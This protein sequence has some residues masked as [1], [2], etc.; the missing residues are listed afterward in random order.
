MGSN[1]CEYLSLDSVQAPEPEDLAAAEFHLCVIDLIQPLS[2]LG[3]LLLCGSMP[4]FLQELQGLGGYHGDELNRCSG[5]GVSE[6]RQRPVG[7]FSRYC[8][9]PTGN[10]G[11]SIRLLR[12][13]PYRGKVHHICGLA[14]DSFCACANQPFASE[15]LICPISAFPLSL[16][17]VLFC[18]NG[19]GRV[20]WATPKGAYGSFL[21]V[22]GEH[23]VPEL[24]HV[25]HVLCLSELSLGPCQE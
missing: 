6:G 8:F 5:S 2:I 1:H 16:P 19:E 15:L 20:C 24:H 22:L 23:E 4:G 12:L 10:S 9:V 7:G 14:K 11:G 17:S 21:A 13:H 3:D 18:C 25:I